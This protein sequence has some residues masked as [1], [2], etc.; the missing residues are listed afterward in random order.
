MTS[1]F[2]I[3]ECRMKTKNIA[4]DKR[5]ERWLSPVLVNCSSPEKT[6]LAG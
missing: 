5:R 1:A 6:M 4:V 2:G 3:V